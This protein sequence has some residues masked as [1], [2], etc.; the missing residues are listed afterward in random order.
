MGLGDE[1]DFSAE[2]DTTQPGLEIRQ[3]LI[4]HFVNQRSL[5]KTFGAFQLSQPQLKND[6]IY[7]NNSLKMSVRGGLPPSICCRCPNLI[8]EVGSVF[9][10]NS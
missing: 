2:M 8:R 5:K 6:T 4:I 7:L 1:C 9:S 3:F 10:N